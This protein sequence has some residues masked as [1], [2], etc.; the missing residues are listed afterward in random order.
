MSWYSDVTNDISK[1][2]DML[3]YY[4]NELLTAKKECSVYGKVEK[5]LAD[6]PGI[7]IFNYVRLDVSTFKSI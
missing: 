6:L 5:N 4:E 3:L 1:I 7:I 2:P